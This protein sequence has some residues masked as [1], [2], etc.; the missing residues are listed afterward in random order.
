[1]AQATRKTIPSRRWRASQM[2]RALN[3]RFQS[4]PKA[5]AQPVDWR[6]LYGWRDAWVAHRRQVEAAKREERWGGLR[7]IATFTMIS[8][9][10][11]FLLVA[12][13]LGGAS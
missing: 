12:G 8:G 11:I 4:V 1:M 6:V 13:V 9:A 3:G 5:A 2:P 7:A 10:L